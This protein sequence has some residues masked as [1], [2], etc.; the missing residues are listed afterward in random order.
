MAGT[1]QGSTPLGGT[2]ESQATT[3]PETAASLPN[4]QPEPDFIFFHNPARWDVF[5]YADGTQ[6]LLPILSKLKLDPGVGGVTE[7]GDPT[8]AKAARMR[9]G[10]IEIP[11]N[12]GPDDYV[13][14][15]K[16]RNGWLYHERWRQ[17]LRNG[18][19]IIERVDT[20]GFLH[21]LHDVAATLPPPLPE[22]LG[23][24]Q[25]LYR[26]KLLRQVEQ[27]GS[28]P[29]KV[30][31]AEATQ[32]RIEAI[33]EFQE[34]L[35]QGETVIPPKPGKPTL[36]QKLKATVSKKPKPPVVPDAEG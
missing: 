31:N 3:A 28:N 4:K 34:K 33:D 6:E 27:A 2:L 11:R 36:A 1:V 13:Q 9:K 24:R 7:T 12:Y 15:L 5:E 21:F 32:A 16:V 23:G 14:R 10:E 25:E 8:L 29:M 22:V 17:F 30:A 20:D 35:A 18:S 26:A 19:Q